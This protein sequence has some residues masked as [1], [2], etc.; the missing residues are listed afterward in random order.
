MNGVARKVEKSILRKSVYDTQLIKYEKIVANTYIIYP[1]Q[2]IGNKVELFS[3]EKMKSEYPYAYKYLL[4]FKDILDK[5]NMP[6]RTENTWYAY[7]RS[8]SIKRFL[9]G[10]HLIWPVLSLDANYVFD[11]EKI[12]FTG[13]GN[14]PFYGLEMKSDVK[15]SIFMCKL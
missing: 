1:Y 13:G 2:K 3:I 10:N 14:G 6:T 8:Q 9:E 12:S 5:R 15:E 4:A 11:D 7:G